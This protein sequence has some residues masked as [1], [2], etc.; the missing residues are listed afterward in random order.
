MSNRPLY[1]KRNQNMW[2]ENKRRFWLNPLKEV[3]GSVDTFSQSVKCR[4]DPFVVFLVLMNFLGALNLSQGATLR[5]QD[6]YVQKKYLIIP[7]GEGKGQIPLTKYNDERN[8]PLTFNQG[9]NN[10]RISPNG[11]VYVLWYAAALKKDVIKKFL[12]DGTESAACTVKEAHRLLWDGDNLIAINISIGNQIIVMDQ[13]LQS[14]KTIDVP[15]NLWVNKVIIKDGV[16]YNHSFEKGDLDQFVYDRNKASASPAFKNPLDDRIRYGFKISGKGVNIVFKRG[17]NELRSVDLSEF[18][19]EPLRNIGADYF[20][21]LNNVYLQMRL[22]IDPH[23]NQYASGVLKVSNEGEPLA[24][25]N[26]GW[27]DFCSYI[28]DMVPVDV[29]TKGNIYSVKADSKGINIYEWEIK[30]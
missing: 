11:N 8:A 27:D 26:L 14:I 12:P 20:D 6:Q 28:D 15:K 2:N 25:I 4:P 17:G 16:L 18:T 5:E 19:T 21:S 10:F 22:G 3:M 9:I 1:G 30:K 24:W 23:N 13:D 7:W 29:D